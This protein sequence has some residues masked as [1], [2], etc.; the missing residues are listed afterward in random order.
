MDEISINFDASEKNIDINQ[1]KDYNGNNIDVKILKESESD[2]DDF[3]DNS[4]DF[5]QGVAD[6]G[7]ELLAN[8]KKTIKQ[9][10]WN[11]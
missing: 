8:N 3:G 6:I 11:T 9:K 4:P 10:I 7:L 2:N 5:N 1:H